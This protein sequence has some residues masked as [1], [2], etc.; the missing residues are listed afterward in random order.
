[1]KVQTLLAPVLL[2]LVLSA[3]GKEQP[4]AQQAVS[5]EPAAPAAAGE[6]LAMV[7]ISG[8]QSPSAIYGASCVA[9]HGDVGQG[10]GDNPKLA[11]LSR[12]DVASRLKDYRDGK[13]LGPKTAV[14]APA[15]KD[16]TDE[17]IVALAIYVGE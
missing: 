1:M 8:V 4:E 2:A 16:F 17:E 6:A 3:C 7:D 10:V 5:Q 15:V 9:C 11:G 14:M 13:T 12:A